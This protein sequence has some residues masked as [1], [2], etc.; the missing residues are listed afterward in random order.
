MRTIYASH[1]LQ[2]D[3]INNELLDILCNRIKNNGWTS[4]KLSKAYHIIKPQDNSDYSNR[5]VIK[6]EDFLNI[7]NKSEQTSI[8]IKYNNDLSED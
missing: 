3:I 7:L 4:K 8:E 6:V 2:N 1:I 5:T